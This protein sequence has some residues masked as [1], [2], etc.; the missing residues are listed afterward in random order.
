MSEAT[1]LFVLC[2]FIPRKYGFLCSL[3]DSVI[4]WAL[5]EPHLGPLGT[6]VLD[7]GLS[8]GQKDVK[9]QALF[10]PSWTLYIVCLGDADIKQETPARM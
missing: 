6:V 5:T 1:V 9:K 2:L 3:I 7:I 8:A 4:N 10:L